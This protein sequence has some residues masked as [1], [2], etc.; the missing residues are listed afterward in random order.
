MSDHS[1]TLVHR[2]GKSHQRNL[3]TLNFKLRHYVH[4]SLQA[5]YQR[6]EDGRVVGVGLGVFHE[7]TEQ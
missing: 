5:T 6:R 1:C 2:I 3:Q 4:C 7:N